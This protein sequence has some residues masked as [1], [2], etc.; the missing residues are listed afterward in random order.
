MTEVSR[1]QFFK[2]A[3]AAALATAI[4]IPVQEV[5]TFGPFNAS[6][7]G[8]WL[9]CDGSILSVSE[10]PDLFA[11]IGKAYGGDEGHF[12]LPDWRWIPDTNIGTFIK[13]GGGG[14]SFPVGYVVDMV[15][16]KG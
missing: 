2:L 15:I 9:I 11:A 3:G 7:P 6:P 10:F 1:R 16:G 5:L 14:D 4:P 12:R 13:I 8:G